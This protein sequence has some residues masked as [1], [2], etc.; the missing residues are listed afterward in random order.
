LA[1]SYPYTL[2][3]AHYFHA[4][5]HQLGREVRAVQERVQEVLRVSEERGFALFLACGTI[6]R[7]WALV[8]G[9]L[10][11]LEGQSVSGQVQ[12]EEGIGQICEGIAALR[13]IGAAVTLPSSLASLANAYVQVGKIEKALDLMDEALGLVDE[14]GERCW[15]AELHRLKGELLLMVEDQAEAEACFQ[16]ALD[17]ARRQRAKSWE[18]RAAISLS[19][20]WYR[21]DKRAEARALL[22]GIYG[23]FSEGFGTADVVEARGLLDVLT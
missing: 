12:V 1:L 8:Q 4:V 6:L 16:R 18:L 9:R 23:W 11:P 20:L 10:E 21:Q 15:E 17:I 14:N 3:F 2:A 5:L 19:R 22:Q 13:A 7:G